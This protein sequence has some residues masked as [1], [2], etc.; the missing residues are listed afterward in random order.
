MNTAEKLTDQA[1][2]LEDAI[3]PRYDETELRAILGALERFAQR[4]PRVA[5]GH[6]V[7]EHRNVLEKLDRTLRSMN[8]L[9][10]HMLE[11]AQQVGMGVAFEKAMNAAC[12]KLRVC[13]A[14]AAHLSGQADQAVD[15]P[16]EVTAELQ[17][18][19][20]ERA[21]A[22]KDRWSEEELAAFASDAPRDSADLEAWLDA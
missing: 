11:D 8:I 13:R 14:L 2:E 19:L 4:D 15:E 17:R 9:S 7:G 22:A 6:T 18:L 5:F 21:Q 20:E 3:A 10:E 1:G 12:T 16:T